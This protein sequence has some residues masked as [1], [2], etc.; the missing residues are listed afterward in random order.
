MIYRDDPLSFKRDELS[1]RLETLDRERE[2]LMNEL[3]KLIN[4][5]VFVNEYRPKSLQE[6]TNDR[7]DNL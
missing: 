2:F 4:E 3:E 7:P 5:N 1:R 6:R